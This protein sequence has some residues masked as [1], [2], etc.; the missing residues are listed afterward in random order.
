MSH[1]H[2][3][4]RPVSFVRTIVCRV[5]S[6]SPK[7]GGRVS[8]RHLVSPRPKLV[9]FLPRRSNAR[10]IGTASAIGSVTETGASGKRVTILGLPRLVRP[11]LRL[12]LSYRRSTKANQT[13]AFLCA[14]PSCGL[15]SLLHARVH[16]SQTW[17]EIPSSLL[18]YIH[19]CLR[20][21]CRLCE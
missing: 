18:T 9:S 11:S 20:V 12:C 15:P 5:I 10:R 17:T 21:C 2:P 6:R 16:I 4:F 1:S 3:A 19:S 8:K 7:Q 13:V 14:C